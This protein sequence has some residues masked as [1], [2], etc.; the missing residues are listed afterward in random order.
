[1]SIT[2]ELRE[3]VWQHA[4]NNDELRAIADRIDTEHEKECSKAWM[5]GHDVWAS[6]GNEEVMAERG[7]VRLPVDADGVPIR[8][9][10]KLQLDDGSTFT[11]TSMALSSQGDWELTTSTDWAVCCGCFDMLHHHRDP[12]TEDVL[13]E[14]ARVGIRIASK[15]GINPQEFEFYADEDAIAEY[16]ERLQLKEVDA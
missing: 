10:D 7:W 13:R 3:Y 12:T 11:V 15:D 1:M 6:V 4:T 8:V 5:R 9:G 16:A 2:D 14:F